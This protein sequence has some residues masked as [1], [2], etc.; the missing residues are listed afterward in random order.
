MPL[1]PEQQAAA[2]ALT[3]A[4]GKFMSTIGAG[5]APTTA[6]AA[7]WWRPTADNAAEDAIFL[8]VQVTTIG[9][10]TAMQHAKATPLNVTTTD[11]GTYKRYA[12]RGFRPDGSRAFGN[13]ADY[14]KAQERADALSKAPTP[15]AAEVVIKG[16]GTMPPDVGIALLLWNAV[17]QPAGGLGGTPEFNVQGVQSIQE[18]V[19]AMYRAGGPSGG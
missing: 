14:A 2:D 16:G 10:F 12:S 18:A 1:T 15:Q 19:T 11:D 17:N 7:S 5:P 8:G 9:R 6:T 4:F 3:A 13:E